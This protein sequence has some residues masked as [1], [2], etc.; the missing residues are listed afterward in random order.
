M[1]GFKPRSVPGTGRPRPALSARVLRAVDDA[2]R[3]TDSIAARA[4]T[5]L[6]A[7]RPV[8]AELAER[9]KVVRIEGYNVVTLEPF[10]EQWQ[11]VPDGKVVVYCSDWKTQKCP[12]PQFIVIP[13]D[14]G[15]ELPCEHC[16]SRLQAWNPYGEERKE[17]LGRLN[18][19]LRLRLRARR[20][21]R[22]TR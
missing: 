6:I 21:V 14:E 8:L 5:T 11:R 9:G 15:R 2:L 1:S 10:G 22:A 12:L 4:A 13:E 16:G 17:Q 18:E 20:R 3:N 7:V 19:R